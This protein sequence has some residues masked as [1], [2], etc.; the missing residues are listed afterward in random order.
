[1]AV[2]PNIPPLHAPLRSLA[3]IAPRQSSPSRK[4]K[5]LKPKPLP[6]PRVDL[7]PRLELS[8]NVQCDALPEHDAEVEWWLSVLKVGVGRLVDRVFDKLAD[9]EKSNSPTVPA[10]LPTQDD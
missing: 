6:G 1:M 10:L 3:D 4:R 7:S 5:T 8:L 9:E 2:P